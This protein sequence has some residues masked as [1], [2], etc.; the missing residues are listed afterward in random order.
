MLFV[1]H[2]FNVGLYL[3]RFLVQRFDANPLHVVFNITIV[4]VN[5]E[6]VIVVFRSDSTRVVVAVALPINQHPVSSLE[7]R[8]GRSNGAGCGTDDDGVLRLQDGVWVRD[9]DSVGSIV[10]DADNLAAVQPASVGRAVV[11]DVIANIERCGQRNLGVGGGAAGVAG[12]GLTIPIC[13]RAAITAVVTAAGS[14]F[15]T[16]LWTTSPPMTESCM[17]SCCPLCPGGA[18]IHSVPDHIHLP[19]GLNNGS[20]MGDSHGVG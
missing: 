15:T 3:R 17:L 4:E 2:V 6:G 14:L 9:F 16:V 13:W 20:A 1:H 8:T 18:G 19:S 12:V 11:F 7:G 5:Q 10:V